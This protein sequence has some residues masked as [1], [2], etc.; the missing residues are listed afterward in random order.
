[1]ARK[2]RELY[3]KIPEARRATIEARVQALERELPLHEIRRA[4]SLTQVQL[5]EEMNASQGEI[6]ALERRTDHYVSTLRR[7]VTAMGGELEIVVRFPDGDA[8]KIQQFSALGTGD[9]PATENNAPVLVAARG[10]RAPTEKLSAAR[11]R[12][13]SS[14]TTTQRSAPRK[15]QDAKARHRDNF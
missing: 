11:R 15:K 6:S 13:N 14:L 5:A 8:V 12:D 3:D 1:M 4:R 2:W 9:P 7:Y 10:G